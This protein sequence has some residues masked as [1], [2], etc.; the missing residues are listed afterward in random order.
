M[1]NGNGE[2]EKRDRYQKKFLAT[3]LLLGVLE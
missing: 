1:G 2:D 3:K